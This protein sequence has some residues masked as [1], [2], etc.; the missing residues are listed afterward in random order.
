MKMKGL[1]SFFVVIVLLISASCEKADVPVALPEKGETEYGL[2]EMGEDYV[3]QLFFDFETG[4]VVHVSEINSWHLAF[5]AS[6]EGYHIFM[7]GGADV[8]V[9][10]TGETDMTKVTQAPASGSSEWMFDRSCG[11]P[12]S[13]G[14]GDWRKD[15]KVYIVKVNDTYEP[16]NIKKVKFIS[17]SSDAYT[18]EYADI[19]E[20]ITH[21]ATIPKDP[22]YN[23][24][25]FSFYGD[26]QIVQPDPPKD[27]WDI[28]FTRYR[29]IYY[30]LNNFP[31]IVNGVLLN[32]YKTEA[33]APDSSKGNVTFEGPEV[34]TLP[35]TNFRDEIG[36]NWKKYNFDTQRYEVDKEKMYMVK[37]RR[38]H[39][40]RLNFLD[41]YNKQDVKGSPSFEFLR[42]F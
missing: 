31:Y 11:L 39:Y 22:A 30:D 8:F 38:G 28:V 7:N 15:G 24:S 27:T 25:Y 21:I 6:T 32:P 19:D 12:D 40:W 41:F 17:V 13:T 10:N 37:N 3:N 9:Y 35:Y 18:I 33:Y 42:L 2:V 23:Y 14:I 16:N 1:Q 34:L 36:Y 29:I 5:E 4:S 26:G 20:S